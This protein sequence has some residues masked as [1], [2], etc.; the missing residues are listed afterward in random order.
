MIYLVG[1]GTIIL[2]IVLAGT[3]FGDIDRSFGFSLF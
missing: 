2:Q 3:S 1:M